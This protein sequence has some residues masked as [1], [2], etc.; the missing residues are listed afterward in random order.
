MKN[1]QCSKC[2]TH[3]KKDS[4]PSYGGCPKGGNHDWKDL[5]TVGNDNYQCKK[6]AL[7]VQSKST[8]SYGGCP[9]GGNH[10][11]KKL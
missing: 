5:G 6:C 3:I 1:Y 2:A 10:D 8:P 11:W 7:L 9:S 4:T